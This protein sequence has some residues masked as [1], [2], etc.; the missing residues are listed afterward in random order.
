MIVNISDPEIQ[1]DLLSWEELDQKCDKEVVAFI[2][3][4]EL[5]QTVFNKS[6]TTG[7]AEVSTYRSRTPVDP[8]E[9]TMASK[10]AL[11]G[12][13]KK[14]NQE[15]S[16]YKRYQNGRMNRL[17]FTLCR[18]CQK[19]VN[20]PAKSDKG[21]VSADMTLSVDSFFIGG[22]DDY[23]SSP[24]ICQASSAVFAVTL[25]HH[26]FTHDRGLGAGLRSIISDFAVANDHKTRRL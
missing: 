20:Q 8:S 16:L 2:E 17:A 19:S 22:V 4:K 9:N 3:S 10:L 5:A 25:D 14:F 23:D 13:C 21:T 1:K 24:D 11:K 6:L 7:T 12:K 15:I 26:I 18:Q